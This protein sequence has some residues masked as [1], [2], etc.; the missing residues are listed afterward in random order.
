MYQID[1][2]S[3]ATPLLDPTCGSWDPLSGGV[4]FRQSAW[5]GAWWEHLAERKAEPYLVA[6][7]RPDGRLCGLLPLYR[8]HRGDGRTLSSIGDGAA[9]TD[10]WSVLA[11]ESD[12]AINIAVAIGQWLVRA[13]RS[14]TDGWDV[15]D[16]DGLV[17]GDSAAAALQQGLRSA[18]ALTLVCS[19]MNVWYK[20]T[21]DSWEQYLMSLGKTHRRQ[22]RRLSTAVA[23]TEGM[24]LHLPSSADQVRD[25]LD[26]LINLHQRRWNDVGQPGSFASAAMRRFIHDAAL[27]F[28]H[29]GQ[30]RLPTLRMEGQVIAAELHIVGQNGV[31]YCYSTGMDPQFAQLEPGRILNAESLHHAYHHG[32]AG[33]DLMRGDEPY[34][35]R[36]HALPRPVARL[37]AV[38]PALLPRLRHAAWRTGFEVKQWIRR[39]TGRTPLAMIDLSQDLHHSPSGRVSIDPEAD[40]ARPANGD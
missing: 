36:M 39:R 9:C 33:I 27:R 13:A 3:N 40:P 22:L 15:M 24:E 2:L 17:A 5:L 4:P 11:G 20:P 29:R 21:G 1:R 12:D 7:R 14:A 30:L 16:V 31:M 10:H 32:L 8:H 26:A 18:G 25:S 19:R 34:K 28:F 35:Q 37:R 6:A 23:T 38:A